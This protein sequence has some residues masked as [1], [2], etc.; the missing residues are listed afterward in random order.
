MEKSCI[1]IH[2][3]TPLPHRTTIY[4]SKNASGT[5]LT[6]QKPIYSAILISSK[7]SWN[8]MPSTTFQNL[9]TPMSIAISRQGIDSVR[10]HHCASSQVR[11]LWGS[12]P[13]SV[14]LMS[15]SSVGRGG[16]RSPLGVW[17]RGFRTAASR[18]TSPIVLGW[19]Q[20]TS[21]TRHRC[22]CRCPSRFRSPRRLLC[23]CRSSRR[24]SSSSS[25]PHHP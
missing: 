23:R 12:P 16:T 7:T 11:C 2:P 25:A 17:Q 6:P 4:H 10:N 8:K 13:Q 5:S 14:C 19:T 21:T 22:P 3:K 1:C 20:T 24:M 15:A 18:T 9:V